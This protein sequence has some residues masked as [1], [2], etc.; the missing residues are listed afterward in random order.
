MTDPLA[1]DIAAVQAID[2]VRRILDVICQVTGMG[3]S[4]V[5]RVTETRWVACQV[6]DDVGLG[7]GPGGELQI[8]ETM[9]QQVR[10]TGQL[11]V[12]N[13][14]SADPVWSAHPVPAQYGIESY[15]SMPIFTP[16]GAFFGTLCALDPKPSRIESPEQVE[17]IRIFAELIGVHLATQ[18]R[19]AVTEDRLAAE[20][21]TAELREQFIAVLGHDLRNPLA[22]IRAGTRLL[23]RR[24]P[25]A[26]LRDV[27]GSIEAS[28]LRMSRLIDDVTDFARGRLGGGLPVRVR[29]AVAL[30]AVLRQVAG[31]VAAG[32]AGRRIEVEVAPGLSA[33]CDPDRVAQLAG[34]LL[35]NAVTHGAPVAPIRV[36]ARQDG[37][38][39]EVRVENQGRPIP[40]QEQARLFKP[41]ERGRDAEAGSKGLGLG[42][43][44]ASEIAGAHG[45]WLSVESG[46]EATAF[47][48]R[49]PGEMPG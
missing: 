28:A 41:F 8:T 33:T 10:D 40:P 30:E 3:F 18:E 22:A 35:A 49:F 5:A 4:A 31:E 19:L 1:R 45:G 16:D 47:V 44:I 48:F 15:I 14:A 46:P 17:M 43:Y 29:Q 38:M 37:A 21:R 20:Q 12:F 11:V 6:R 24:V 2:A 32:A 9:C 27:V 25:E 36:V 26:G 13:S 34:N 39:V 42:L 23:A 7:L